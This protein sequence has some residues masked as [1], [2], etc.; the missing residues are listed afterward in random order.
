M[1]MSYTVLARKYRPQKLE[2]LIGQDTLV[3]VLTNSFRLNRIAHAF[4]LTGSRGVGKTTTARIIAKGLN[5]ENTNKNQAPTVNPCGICSSCVSITESRHI[6]VLEMD[7]ASRTGVSDVREIIENID[8]KT[9][10]ALYKVYIIDEVHMLSNSAFNA[11]LK[12]L[13]EPPTHVKFIF[14][15]TEINKIPSTVISRCQRFDLSR[16]GS[17]QITKYLGSICEKE[18]IKFSSESLS[19][20]SKVADGSL[21]DSLSILDQAIVHG[22]GEIS[23][24]TVRSMLG[25]IEKKKSVQNIIASDHGAILRELDEQ[26]QAGLDPLKTI[27]SLMELVSILMMVKVNKKLDSAV[28]YSPDD[29]EKINSMASDLK[30]DIISRCWQLLLKCHKEL[31]NAPDK[32][33]ALKMGILRFS[34]YIKLPSPTELIEKLDATL[35]SNS[36]LDSVKEESLFLVEFLE[37]TTDHLFFL[38]KKKWG[39]FLI[40]KVRFFH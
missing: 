10:S 6:D 22:S 3:R 38:I 34:F 9:V 15:T 14:A 21:R 8:Y 1:F 17:D 26:H 19:L 7:A 40:W 30:M 12:T 33:T 2:D 36:G 5:C 31:K 4:I 39:L 16:I 28:T 13:E 37:M 32:F 23:A 18:N 25:I 27:D 29:Q 11:L 35:R 20:I 24:V